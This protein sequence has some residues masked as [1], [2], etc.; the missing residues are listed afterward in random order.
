MASVA[1]A[2]TYSGFCRIYSISSTA[3]P[4]KLKSVVLIETRPREAFLAKK[5]LRTFLLTQSIVDPLMSRHI[6]SYSSL[7]I[8]LFSM[9]DIY[10]VLQACTGLQHPE[11]LMLCAVAVGIGVGG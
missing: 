9:E 5:T 6:S 10:K 3:R 8:I 11:D 2:L 7:S 4:E 1:V